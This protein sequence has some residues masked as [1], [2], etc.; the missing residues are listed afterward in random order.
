MLIVEDAELVRGFEAEIDRLMAGS[1]RVDRQDPTW[2]RLAERRAWMRH[3][4]GVLT[5]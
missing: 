2:Q 5:V 1:T 3:W 4:P